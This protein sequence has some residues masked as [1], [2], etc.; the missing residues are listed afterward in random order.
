MYTMSAQ[1]G[2]YTLVYLK[3]HYDIASI[4]T[5][6]SARHFNGTK[7]QSCWPIECSHQSHYKFQ[8]QNSTFLPVFSAYFNNKIACHFKFCIGFWQKHGR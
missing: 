7:F 3:I 5:K 6:F 2:E 8:L 4:L 1:C